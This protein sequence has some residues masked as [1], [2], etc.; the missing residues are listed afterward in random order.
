[1]VCCPLENQSDK[2]I[3]VTFKK[4]RSPFHIFSY[5]NFF[6]WL[7]EILTAD[8]SCIWLLVGYSP[9]AT[10]DKEP[11]YI[12][13]VMQRAPGLLFIKRAILLVT[14]GDKQNIANR[15][16]QGLLASS[17]FFSHD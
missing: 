6:D 5:S 3:L 7:L 15:F 8:F 14:N 9:L 10:G 11:E 12:R 2:P 16:R 4:P 1:M 13:E 17:I